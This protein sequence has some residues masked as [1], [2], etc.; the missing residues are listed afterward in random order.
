V[1]VRYRSGD[2]ETVVE[3]TLVSV[4]GEAV[5]VET[6]ARRARAPHPREIVA[7]AVRA[8]ARGP[9]TRIAFADVVAGRLAVE[10]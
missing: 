7:G 5:E 10:V 1:N 3:G 9:V 2:A 6:A 8:E 4:E